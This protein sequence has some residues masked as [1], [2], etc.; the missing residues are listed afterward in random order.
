MAVEGKRRPSFES[1]D[2]TIPQR[3]KGRIPDNAIRRSALLAET[4]TAVL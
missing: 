4:E 2:G 3:A 1:G